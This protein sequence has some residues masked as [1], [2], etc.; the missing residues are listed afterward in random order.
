MASADEPTELESLVY[1]LQRFTNLPELYD[2]LSDAAVRSKPVDAQLL[3]F[4][5]R[6]GGMTLF[7][8]ARDKV[9]EMVRD[10]HV[11]RAMCCDATKQNRERLA[12]IYHLSPHNI[13]QI[14]ARV[15]RVFHHHSRAVQGMLRQGK[16]QRKTLLDD[17]EGPGE[18]P[19]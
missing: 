4:L 8:P 6:F 7:I 11:F 3:L 18:L 13:R 1:L 12:S 5:D 17:K 19:S 14:H 15:S 16:A 9:A 2:F 10:I